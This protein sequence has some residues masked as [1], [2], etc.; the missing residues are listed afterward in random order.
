MKTAYKT[1]T[2]SEYNVLNKIA[3]RTGMDCWFFLAQDNDGT[4][5]I[6]DLEEQKRLTLVDGVCT[7][8][9]GIEDQ[10]NYDLCGLTEEE[11]KVFCELLVKL[12]LYQ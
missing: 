4:D 10:E 11:S 12:N 1:L 5:Y 7:L 2:D 9:E 3:D 8:C 6:W